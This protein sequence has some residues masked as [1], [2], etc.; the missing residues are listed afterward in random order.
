[1][2]KRDRRFK[3]PVI[4]PHTCAECHSMAGRSPLDGPWGGNEVY[5]IGDLREIAWSGQSKW[6]NPMLKYFP[7]RAAF[8]AAERQPRPV[9]PV[10]RRD[11][12][13]HA[14]ARQRNQNVLR[15]RVQQMTLDRSPFSSGDTVTINRGKEIYLTQCAACHGL[16]AR[17]RGR[18]ALRRR[19]PPSIAGAK[20]KRIIKALRQGHGTMPNFARTL[21]GDEQWRLVEYLQTLKK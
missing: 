11:T 21:P 16:E 10:L 2:G 15:T 3:W 9:D 19:P 5:S 12:Y 13:L 20:P 4:R 6:F 17:G 8:S 7:G 1:M 14:L 18:L